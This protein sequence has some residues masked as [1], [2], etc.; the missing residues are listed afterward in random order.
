MPASTALRLVHGLAT[1]VLLPISAAFRARAQR[2]GP[3]ATAAMLPGS[4]VVLAPHPDDET[5]GCSVL[6][7]R[8]IEAGIPVHIVIATDGARSHGEELVPPER[9]AALRRGESIE[10]A[11]RL[12][13]TEDDLTF[14]GYPDGALGES[15]GRLQR[16]LEAVL[17]KHRPE[18]VA[19]TSSEDAHPDHRALALV[20]RTAIVAV[21]ATGSM[22][23]LFEY[24]IWFW[25]RLPW[26][27]RPSSLAGALW[28]FVRDPVVELQ[29]T[30]PLRVRTAGYLT[31][32]RAALDAHRTQVRPFPP[33]A[34][35]GPLL[36]PDF[37]EHFFQSSE[38]Y[39][40]IALPA[41]SETPAAQPLGSA[42]EAP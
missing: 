10:A 34:G 37:V 18:I 8:K 6:M 35:G 11:R 7:L 32:K 16:D 24:P 15:P 36:R 25:E 19:V 5:L 38:V 40:P 9:L 12:G 42:H 39:F 22:P 17:Q 33:G 1:P 23:A 41:R 3:D 4:L 2:R 20:A 13:L 27:H 28:H 14:L 21:G 31:R 30:P 26:I 29:R